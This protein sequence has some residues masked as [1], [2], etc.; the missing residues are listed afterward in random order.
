MKNFLS[1]LFGLSAFLAKVQLL[2][3][4]GRYGDAL[5]K[6]KERYSSCPSNSAPVLINLLFADLCERLGRMHDAAE[7][8]EL[9]LLQIDTVEV[10]G[11]FREDELKYMK[12]HCKWILSSLSKFSDS[13]VFKRAA[14]I[15]LSFDDLA[16]AN[17]RPRLKRIFPLNAEDA[18]KLDSFVLQN[19]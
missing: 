1:E 5:V 17:V 15:D 8:C 18:R 7:A 19:T 14:A 3:S 4:R 2:A 12:Y 9:V 10:R 6:I 11:E 16:L 13:L